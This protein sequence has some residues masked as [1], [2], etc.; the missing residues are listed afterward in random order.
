VIDTCAPPCP[1][2]ASIRSFARFSLGAALAKPI[3][4]RRSN[5][6]DQRSNPFFDRWSKTHLTCGR[7]RSDL[8]ARNLGAALKALVLVAAP[9]GPASRRL[10]SNVGAYF[11]NK[12]LFI[13]QRSTPHPLLLALVL[14]SALHVPASVKNA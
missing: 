4:D 13:R 6:F 2:L 5:P 11:V 9:H 3:F 7:T 10:S 14:L 1:C 8:V 12:C